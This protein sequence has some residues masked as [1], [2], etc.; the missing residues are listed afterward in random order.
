MA[1]QKISQLT[2]ITNTVVDTADLFAIVDTSAGSTKKITAGN[3]YSINS[4]LFRIFDSSDTTKV[5]AFSLSGLTTA[6]TRTITVPD[7]DFTMVGTTTTQTLTNKTL[8]SP[9]ITSGSNSKGDMFQLSAT[10]GTLTHLRASSNGD[11]PSW[12]SSTEQ[13]EA[14]ANPAASDASTTAKG[15]I[16]I[17]TT[18]EIT[19]GTST[20]STGAILVV[21][22]SAVGSAGA[23]KIVQFDG[24]G[25]YPAADGSAITN[26][27]ETSSTLLYQSSSSVTSSTADTNKNTL[28]TKSITGGTLSTGNVIRCV[29]RGTWNGSTGGVTLTLRFEYGSTVICTHA[30]ND[31]SGTK[32]INFEVDFYLYATG[33]TGTQKGTS[34]FRGFEAGTTLAFITG[35]YYLNNL[36][37][38]TA[39]EDST[40]A[41][42]LLVTTQLSSTTNPPSITITDYIMERVS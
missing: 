7:A 26:L 20:G 4:S 36:V 25:N 16:E 2:A 1:D 3:L 6:T 30:L 8:T 29:F 35:K 37:S 22:A 23:S 28:I 39:T 13:W 33:A 9:K 12:N 19:A 42:N 24:S 17:A 32:T 34:Y 14:I 5:I 21:P 31:T 15:V 10:D 11:I 38:G 18:A 27:T 41:L 40:G